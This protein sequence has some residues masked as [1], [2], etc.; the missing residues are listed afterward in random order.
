[1]IYLKKEDN[2]MEKFKLRLYVMG[3]TPASQN[4]IKDL[5]KVLETEKSTKGNYELDVIDVLKHPQLADDEK[6]IATPALLKV[7][8]EPI[9][10]IL[11]DLSDREKVLVGLDLIKVK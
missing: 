8:P 11:G 9:R 4:A 6:I 5:K 2:K 1:L 7:L 3:G 10:R